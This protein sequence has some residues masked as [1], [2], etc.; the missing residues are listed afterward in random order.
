MK[1]SLIGIVFGVVFV[2]AAGLVLLNSGKKPLQT[3]NAADIV[4]IEIASYPPNE[5][6]VIDKKENIEK[7]V[8]C[9]KKVVVINQV[10]QNDYNGHSYVCKLTLKDSSHRE[11][12]ISNPI[13][14]ID[15]VFYNTSYSPAEKLDALYKQLN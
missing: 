12:V 8:D 6:K 4:S 1:K 15:G 3:L 11:I 5:A 13:V 9:L 10:K 7:V 14:S 2:L